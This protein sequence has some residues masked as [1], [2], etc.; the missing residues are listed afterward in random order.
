MY[1]C[2]CSI[3]CRHVSRDQDICRLGVLGKS[4]CIFEVIF[5]LIACKYVYMYVCMYVC[6]FLCM[7]VANEIL[8]D[9]NNMKP[10]NEILVDKEKMILK[11][12]AYKE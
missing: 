9:P 2:I 5:L 6:M 8:P 7:H 3:V 4:S 11:Y 10:G 12:L 1:V